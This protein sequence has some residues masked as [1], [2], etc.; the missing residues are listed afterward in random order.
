MLLPVSRSS[1]VCRHCIACVCLQY[2]YRCW[3]YESLE[4]LRKLVL[5]SVVIFVLPG[6]VSQIAIGL[7]VS[8]ASLVLHVGLAAFEEDSADNLQTLCL[9]QICCVLFSG[10]LLKTG[11]AVD[12]GY[13]MTFFTG[14]IVFLNYSVR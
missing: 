7:L 6:S 5:S 13:D 3:Y 14:L 4:L 11:T 9:L 8:V 10:L 1:L 12:D 2:E